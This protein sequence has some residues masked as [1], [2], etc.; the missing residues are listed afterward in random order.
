[1][2]L[3]LLGTASTQSVS[4]KTYIAPIFADTTDVTKR[5]SFNLSNLGA[6][7]INSFTVPTGL[8]TL[9]TSIFVTELAS[10]TLRNKIYDLPIF[11]DARSVSRRVVF[12][13]TNITQSRT[14]KFPDGNATLLSTD[15]AGSL[16]GITFGGQI[17]AD[18]FGGRLRLQ[19]HFQSGW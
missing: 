15:N 16:S 4:N 13:L 14:I 9:A 10:Q 5:I 7:T 6:S 3:T 18:S 8:N 17:A 2:S 19:T 12:D 1:L 11:T